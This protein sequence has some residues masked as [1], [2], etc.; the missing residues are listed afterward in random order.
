MGSH[1]IFLK[2]SHHFGRVSLSCIYS[3]ILEH[4]VHLHVFAHLSKHNILC[5]QQH[6]FRQSRSCETQL[7]ITINDFAESLSKNEQTVVI[8]LDFLRCPTSTN[9]ISYTIM[10]YEEIY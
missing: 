6:G 2:S 7:I 9:F 5:D 4:V 10:V 8:F 1:E 3:K